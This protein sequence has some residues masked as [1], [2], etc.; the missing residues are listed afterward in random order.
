MLL[1]CCMLIFRTLP[2]PARCN[3]FPLLV[4]LSALPR[5]QIL[6]LSISCSASP[7]LNWVPIPVHVLPQPLLPPYPSFYT[8]FRSYVPTTLIYKLH[9]LCWDIFVPYATGFRPN[10]GCDLCASQIQS[11]TITELFTK[12]R[13]NEP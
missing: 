11:K 12:S 4:N 13:L 1:F 9:L 7:L 8:L 10:V 6:Y 2:V 5:S 3:L